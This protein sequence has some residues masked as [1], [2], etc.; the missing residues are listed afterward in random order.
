MNK[1]EFTFKISA[2]TFTVRL[3]CNSSSYPLFFYNFLSNIGHH[4]KFFCHLN[5]KKYV[6][7]TDVLSS[8]MQ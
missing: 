8:S 2:Q 7:C 3:R 1:K 4:E 6:S 5:I